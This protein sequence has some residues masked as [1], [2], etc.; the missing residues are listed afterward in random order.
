M[1][2]CHASLRASS[3]TIWSSTVTA[4]TQTA[5]SESACTN[6]C[7]RPARTNA[8]IAALASAPKTVIAARWRRPKARRPVISLARY[9]RPALPLPIR[10]PAEPIETT[11]H[12]RKVDRQG[13]R[14]ERWR[15]VPWENRSSVSRSRPDPP[16]FAVVGHVE[17]VDFIRVT[18]VP[19]PGEIV[20]AR[21]SWAEAAGGGAVAAVQLAKL[22][23][24]ASFF[25]ALGNDDAGRRAEALL[26][27]HG[28]EV[29]ARIRAR[30]QR[31]AVA[32]LDAGG[33]RTIAVIG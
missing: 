16:R 33:E 20:E 8:R 21:D 3:A 30:P 25:T 1:L 6:W 27:S 11:L 9:P 2:R 19:K 23:G 5:A 28:V 31:R 17:W 22:A 10:T 26:R 29:E 24:A 13:G 4:S 14:R 7:R 12:D 32:F 15:V 18:R